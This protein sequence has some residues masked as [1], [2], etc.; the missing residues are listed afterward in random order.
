MLATAAYLND[1][2][3]QVR[4]DLEIYE[5][6]LEAL[7]ARTAARDGAAPVEPSGAFRLSRESVARFVRKSPR[8]TR[9]IIEAIAADGKHPMTPALARVMWARAHQH[10]LVLEK[11]GVVARQG[12]AWMLA[13][14]RKA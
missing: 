3:R 14:G 13:G 2:I 12:K 10:L 1:R 8:S 9:E 7:K 5:R 11:R 6:A 4:R